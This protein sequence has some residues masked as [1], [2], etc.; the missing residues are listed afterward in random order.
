[1]KDPVNNFEIPSEWIKRA[2]LSEDELSAGIASGRL[3]L[4]ADGSVLRR[5]Y[6][7]GTTATAAAKA[8]VL[9]LKRTIEHVTVLTPVGIEVTLPV[10]AS[11]GKASVIKDCGDH[12]FDV[13]GGIEIVAE[14]HESDGA[15]N[16]DNS[17]DGITITAGGGI[18]V[19]RGVPAINPV[20]L[21]QIRTAIRKAV[22]E[23]GISGTDVLI[24]VPR[25]EEIALETLNSRVGVTCGISILGTTGFVE[26]W[27]EHLLETKQELIQQADRVVLT[28]G[29]L[30]MRYSNMLFPDHTVVM[31]GNRIS[32]GLA[33]AK[34]KNGVIVCGL[35]GLILKW[36]DPDILRGSGS[37]TT[38]ELIDQNPDDIR[39]DRTLA[40]AKEDA[41]CVRIVLLNRDG[42][43]LRDYTP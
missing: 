3:V 41:P 20:P 39:I 9:S 40:A 33:A 19:K 23:I 5:G 30:G 35:P 25:G 31:V 13:T 15:G 6:T 1:M 10:S 17:G 37:L 18:G 43:I 36:I 2:T 8:A 16:A 11:G 29:R 21:K 22:R 27:N 42:S 24:Y 14:A 4:L 38:Q 7:T 26:P 28:T 32:E 34:D 12:G